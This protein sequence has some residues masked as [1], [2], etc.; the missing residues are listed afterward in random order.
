MVGDPCRDS[1][2]TIITLQISG[3]ILAVV[4]KGAALMAVG[5]RGGIALVT[6]LE[7]GGVVEDDISDFRFNNKN[8]LIM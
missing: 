1:G 4:I 7:I 2:V 8:I 5:I 6:V 3:L